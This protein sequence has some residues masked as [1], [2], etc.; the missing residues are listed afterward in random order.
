MDTVLKR[1]P[2]VLLPWYETNRRDLPWRSDREPYHVWLSEIMLQQTRVEAVKGYYARF[3][4]A[5]P[6]IEALA[7]ADDELL[8]KLWEGLGY[9]SRV[10]NLKK[11]AQ[12]V[13]E[14]H[15]GV[16]P[17]KYEDILAL[18]GIGAY[19]AGAICSIAFHQPKA[20]V[21]GNVLRVVSRLTEDDTPIDQPAYKKQVQTALEAVYPEDAGAFTQAL[22][23][24]GATLCGPNWKPRCAECP[25]RSFC[26]GAIHGTAEQFPVKK[27]KAKRKIEERTVL[28]LSCDGRYALEKRPDTG[29]LA[30]LWQFPNVCGGLEP[31]IAVR[32]V[33]EIGLHPRQLRRMVER[34]HIFTHIQW[35]MRGIYIEVSE[36][37]GEFA[38]M[39]AEEINEKAALPTAFRQFWEEEQHV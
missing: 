3:L 33:E 26:G 29:L 17:G 35:K 8:H 10:R 19:T 15:G 4:D 1:L 11:A 36:P 27:P 7:T 12:V 6:T 32:A 2:E 25:C 18:P 37:S 23:E 14:R 24:L 5:L 16:F 30:G 21:D 13:M 34:K 31:E 28:I 9:Y 39:T 22:M 38:W 20:A